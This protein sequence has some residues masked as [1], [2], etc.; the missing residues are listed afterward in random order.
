MTLCWLYGDVWVE[1]LCGVVRPA[2]YRD[3]AITWTASQQKSSVLVFTHRRIQVPEP[4]LRFDVPFFG[5]ISY[6]KK[7][8][9]VINQGDFFLNFL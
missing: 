5:K 1:S 8:E 2:C 9:V 6:H 3:A 7:A 4:D